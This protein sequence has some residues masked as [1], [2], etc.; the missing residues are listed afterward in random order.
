LDR[1]GASAD[2]QVTSLTADSESA[3]SGLVAFITIA[4]E[5][6]QY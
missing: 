1:S 3:Y 5:K 2:D 6:G 4:V